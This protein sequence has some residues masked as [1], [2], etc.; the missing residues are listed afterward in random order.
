MSSAYQD[1][2]LI[3]ADETAADLRLMAMRGFAE[4]LQWTPSYEFQASFGVEASRDHLVVEHGLENSA[5]ISF[6]KAPYLAR[7][8]D[9][10]QLRSLL[11]IS[12]NNLIE[13]HIFVSQGDIRQI[14]NLAETSSGDQIFSL[15]RS[16]F[17]AR[18][19]AEQFDRYASLDSISRTLRPC[20]DALINVLSRWK[21]LLKAD[22][23]NADNS[24][25][26]ALFNAIIFT[27]GCEDRKLDKRSRAL[28]AV[29]NAIG[30]ND[31]DLWLVLS[32]TLADTGVR[33]ELNDYVS[34][35]DLVPFRRVDKATALN[36]FSDF[37]SPR[38]AAYDFNFALMSKHALS[39]VYERYVSL[40]SP[41]SDLDAQQLGFINPVP[42]EE[43]PK[44]T[45]AVYTPQF[46]AGFFLVTSEI[47]RLRENLER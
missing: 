41:E 21:R 37:Y 27:R 39:R 43:V 36:L 40:L 24:N 2:Q 14:N 16:D 22:Y 7:D 32:K 10:S 19:S 45:G 9:V 8:L 44:R 3:V 20:D 26:S 17:E 12:Y 31:V 30:G 4:Q 35:E 28:M 38:D 1:L 47:I 23:P 13:W 42:G 34:P 15:S 25:I 29:L 18:L 6:L 5:I 33:G 46:V 11:A